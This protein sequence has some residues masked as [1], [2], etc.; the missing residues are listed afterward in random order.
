MSQ[1]DDLVLD[2]HNWDSELTYV[3]KDIT[4]DFNLR[5]ATPKD[6]K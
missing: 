6:L 3:M 5:W 1:L 4:D 2:Y